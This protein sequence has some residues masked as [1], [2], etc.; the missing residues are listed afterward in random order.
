VVSCCCEKLAP[1]AG[2][3]SGT[4]GKTSAVGSRYQETASENVTVETNVCVYNKVL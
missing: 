2:D 1:E 3:G 4:Q